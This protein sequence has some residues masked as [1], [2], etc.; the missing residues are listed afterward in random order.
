MTPHQDSVTPELLPCPFCGGEPTLD[1]F[2][3]SYRPD[4]SPLW[5][6]IC[7]SRKCQGEI[8]FF[9]ADRQIAIDEW[10]TRP[11]CFSSRFN[12]ASVGR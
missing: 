10:N 8:G 2:N 11:T 12:V 3:T 1:D 9:N 4:S 7:K 6:V 5:G